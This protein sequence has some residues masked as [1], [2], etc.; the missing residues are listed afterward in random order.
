M[1]STLHCLLSGNVSQWMP[2]ISL[3]V[4]RGVMRGWSAVETPPISYK[5][6]CA[7]VMRDWWGNGEKHEERCKRMR[8]VAFYVE[9][10][11]SQPP[12]PG[13]GRMTS[14]SRGVVSAG[15]R[16][17]SRTDPRAVAQWC[18]CRQVS[19]S[20]RASW[21]CCQLSCS[22]NQSCLASWILTL[23]R[24]NSLSLSCL[25]HL[26]DHQGMV[27]WEPCRGHI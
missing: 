14:S 8:H 5:Q 22:G 23:L 18:E 4:I 7:M 6:T 24:C 3:Q 11:G 17:P 2:L 1:L 21:R 25:C 15:A 16:Q 20:I 10:F 27:R 9:T 12:G 19:F 13:W 26:S